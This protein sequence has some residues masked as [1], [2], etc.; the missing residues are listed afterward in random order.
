MA[1]YKGTIRF[2]G[3]NSDWALV[4][5]KA[6]IEDQAQTSTGIGVGDDSQRNFSATLNPVVEEGELVIIVDGVALTS[7]EASDSGGVIT[8]TKITTSTGKESTIDYETGALNIWFTVAATPALDEVVAVSYQYSQTPIHYDGHRLVKGDFSGKAV[9][10]VIYYDYDADDPLKDG[11]Y[12]T[13]TY[14]S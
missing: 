5:E 10:D 13:E 9:G 12:I 4:H 14:Q 11:R 3:E 1:D 7:A 2:I 6:M 8:G